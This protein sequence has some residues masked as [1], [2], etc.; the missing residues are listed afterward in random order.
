MPVEWPQL[1]LIRPQ[2]LWLLPLLAALYLVYRRSLVDLPKRQL[3][4]SLLVRG[5]LFCL[6]ALA[7]AGLNLMIKT[8]SVFTVFVVDQ[9][10]SVDERGQAAAAQFVQ[11]ATESGGAEQFAILP[12]AA[13]PGDFAESTDALAAPQPEKQWRKATSLED[14]IAVASAGIPPE[15]VPHIVLLC[16]GNETDGDVLSLLDGTGAR[17]STV[18]LPVRD[19]PEL[20]VTAVNVPGQVAEGEPFSVEVVVD[21]NHDD[22]AVI[23]VFAGDFRV[24]SET[25]QIATGEN[26]F[27]F[28]Q[29][30]TQPTEFSARIRPPADTSDSDRPF[31]D[32]FL[33]NNIAAGLV[34]TTGQPKV[35]MIEGDPELAKPMQWAMKEEGIQLDV[36]PA[37]GMPDSLTELQEFEVLIL[38]NVPA[39]DLTAG[40]M[41]IIRSYVSELGGG[42]IML[43]GDESFGLGGYYKTVV[44]EV[45]PVRGD[46]E[47]EKEKPGLGM[48]LIIDKSGS[49]GG[50]K[51]ELAK[52]AAR[53]AVDLLS[54]KDQIGVIAFDGAPFWVSK[55]LPG[56]QKG[57]VLDRIAGIEAGGGTALYPAMEEA[58]QALQSTTA[59]L[60]HVII[61]TDGYSTPGDFDGITQEMTAARITVSTVGIGDA[62]QA[63]LRKI[64]DAG[65][66]RYYFSSDASAIP[67]IFAKE[68]ITASKSAI[69]EEPFLPI[70]VRATS[71]LDGISMDDAPFLLGHV[72][73]RPKA[74][75]EVILTTESGDPLLAWWRYGLGVSAAWT[76]D[77]KSRWAAEW[78]SWP[79]FNKFWAQVIRH[80][81]RKSDDQG[82]ELNVQRNGR[83]HWV[84]IDAIN[85]DGRFLNDAKTELTL[86]G[87]DLKS[88]SVEVM[89]TAPGRYEAEIETPTPGAWH[90]QV[91]QSANGQQLG[92][93]SRGIVVGY[94]DEYRL[95]PTNNTKLQSI[96]TATGGKFQP[97]PEDVFVASPGE[98]A[99]RAVPLWPWLL[100]AAL[101]LLVC[102]VALRRV[103]M[104]H[105]FGSELH[106]SA[107]AIR[108]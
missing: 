54:D 20:Q 87:P 101:I 95:R 47:K 8:D 88:T 14:A 7:L 31:R 16:D 52:E 21:A 15:F 33:D 6:L 89:Q 58:F 5:L 9:S 35:L 18:P 81:M 28:T 17:I 62:D 2:W 29:Q 75:S 78:L 83:R 30:V 37:V 27:Q 23:E 49:M 66:G 38:S 39:T 64:A 74:T 80:A 44:E 70:M 13:E 84:T 72:V 79:G 25:K 1:E 91:T 45:L 40:Q 69:K 55:M 46:F 106:R 36:R 42:F 108:S 102:D 19:D 92:Q 96:A 56:S 59:R 65:G 24:I 57:V 103:T 105:V 97:Q 67:Q 77:A 71:V 68:T 22:V 53:S 32:S 48:V 63:M 51:I 93:R 94:G 76:S 41:D 86:V 100:T 99:S 98:S 90:L 4:A 82:F 60:K 10:L 61:L 11:R 104:P 26:R 107:P 34:F 43:G 50:Q 73:T 12:F 3:L 85:V